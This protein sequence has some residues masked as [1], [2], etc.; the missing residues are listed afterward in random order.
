MIITNDSDF[1]ERTTGTGLNKITPGT[2]FR[3]IA[4][5]ILTLKCRHRYVG[6]VDLVVEKKLVVEIVLRSL[7]VCVIE[8]FI[9]F[10]RLGIGVSNFGLI[11]FS[12]RLNRN[13]NSRKT[14]TIKFNT[15][16]GN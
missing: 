12:L 5:C 8:R 6:Y 15:F 3:S 10:G 16:P 11:R 4:I 1:S 14:V 9:Y 2:Q 7:C 13:C